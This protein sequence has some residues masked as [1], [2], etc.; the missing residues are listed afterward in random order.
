MKV[1]GLQQQMLSTGRQPSDEETAEEMGITIERF[2][3]VRRA[4]A[5]ASRSNDAT[6]A[7]SLAGSSNARIQFDEATWER[8]VGAQSEGRYEYLISC[9]VVQ[10]DS[11]WN[12]LSTCHT[13]Y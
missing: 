11:K 4:M 6:P 1:R 9:S 13:V 8:V 2:E 7:L 3:V 5:L 10:H 12:V